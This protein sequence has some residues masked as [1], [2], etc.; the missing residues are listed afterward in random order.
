MKPR[1]YDPWEI[2]LIVKF[3]A[4]I[5]INLIGPCGRHILLL[6]PQHQMNTIKAAR[7]SKVSIRRVHS[8][9]QRAIRINMSFME[10]NIMA[11]YCYKYKLLRWD[12]SIKV[13]DHLF[14]CRRDPPPVG[15]WD[16]R[17][18][19]RSRQRGEDGALINEIANRGVIE[20]ISWDINNTLLDFLFLSSSSSINSLICI[21]GTSSEIMIMRRRMRRMKMWIHFHRRV[22]CCDLWN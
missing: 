18:W 11:N 17:W 5:D 16:R 7:G 20:W 1:I 8:H 2:N 9:W 12:D 14:C 21:Q 19:R 4:L 10:E 6:L 15:A 13:N 3:S 22:V